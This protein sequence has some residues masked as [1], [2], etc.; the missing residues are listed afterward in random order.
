MCLFALVLPRRSLNTWS[1]LGDYYQAQ[2]AAS[3]GLITS[4]CERVPSP[5]LFPSSSVVR[6]K[7]TIPYLTSLAPSSFLGPLMLRG[8][9]IQFIFLSSL[10]LSLSLSPSFHVCERGKGGGGRA[11]RMEMR[12]RSVSLLLFGGPSFLLLY[13]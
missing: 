12:S 4:L 2:L 10:S 5:P 3:I 6:R 11:A 13:Y 1:L 7:E 9:L 8:A